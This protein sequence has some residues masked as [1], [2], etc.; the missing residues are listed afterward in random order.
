[1]FGK[2]EAKMAVS[3]IRNNFNEEVPFPI[4]T[5]KGIAE[6][7]PQTGGSSSIL[8][9][10]K[11]DKK[12][13]VVTD[14]SSSTNKA[15]SELDTSEGEFVYRVQ[16]I[17]SITYSIFSLLK[18]ELCKPLALID[19]FYSIVVSLYDFENSDFTSIKDVSLN[20]FYL[21][22]SIV[23]FACSIIAFPIRIGIMLLQDIF[24]S[25]DKIIHIIKC[26]NRGTKAK[27][28]QELLYYLL[29]ITKDILIIVGFF[30][31]SLELTLAGLAIGIII[32]GIKAY[33]CFN[34]GEYLDCVDNLLGFAVDCRDAHGELKKIKPVIPESEIA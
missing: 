12:I 9:T 25:I 11:G 15:K 3:A 18:S 19:D 28:F 13:S 5:G 31:G 2:N 30:Y 26:F 6:K 29:K 1:M 32:G 14:R 23:A 33:H 24:K 4:E 10:S 27:H 21:V 17:V 7:A 16:T 22:E 34:K 8:S 20:L